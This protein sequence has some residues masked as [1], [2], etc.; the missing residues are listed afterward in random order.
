MG[1]NVYK[2]NL[3]GRLAMNQLTIF[4]ICAVCLIIVTI[5]DFRKK[6]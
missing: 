4:I 6:K 2:S 5:M 1:Y 3:K